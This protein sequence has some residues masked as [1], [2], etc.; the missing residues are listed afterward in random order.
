MEWLWGFSE[1]LNFFDS[2]KKSNIWIFPRDEIFQFSPENSNFSLFVESWIFGSFLPNLV[3]L[4]YCEIILHHNLASVSYSLHF[5]YFL[6]SLYSQKARSRRTA[7]TEELLFPKKRG[8][9]MENL[10]EIPEGVSLPH[11]C[12]FLAFYNI[13]I[14]K[15]FRSTDSVGITYRRF[16]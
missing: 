1:K 9:S 11:S 5:L 15:S 10:N 8:F 12:R 6:A 3:F 2:F 7:T 4:L 16:E 13:F 14:I